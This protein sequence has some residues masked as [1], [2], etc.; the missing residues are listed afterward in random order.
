MMFIHGCLPAHT[1]FTTQL[2]ESKIDFPF[3]VMASGCAVEDPVFYTTVTPEMVQ[4]YFIQEDANIWAQEMDVPWYHYLNAIAEPQLGVALGTY[5]LC[6]YGVMWTVK[7]ALERTRYHT[8]INMFRSNFRDAL[9][10]TD[11]S[12]Q[13]CPDEITLPDGST[14][15][16]NLVRGIDQIKFQQGHRPGDL[17]WQNVFSHG[18][19]SQTITINGKG[20]RI[21]VYPRVIFP[22]DAPSDFVWPVPSWA[23][24]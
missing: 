21:P 5:G 19:I 11:I 3:G 2:W 4:Y 14:F 23:E 20:L 18:Q 7:N 16:P 17:Y 24:R 13:N 8:D 1:F 22:A 15:C 9:E 10:Q 12:T 6:Q